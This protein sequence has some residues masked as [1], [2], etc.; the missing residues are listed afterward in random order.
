VLEHSGSEAGAIVAAQYYAER[1]MI[2]LGICDTGFGI[3]R[4]IAPA[5]PG[6][7]RTDLEAIKWALVPGVSGTTTHESGTE[8][9]AGAGLFIVKCM[10]FLAR[11]YF[12]IYSGSGVYKLLKRRPDVKTALLDRKSAG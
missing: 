8:T 12:L 5:W 7:A 3:R 10:S 2:R 11:N 9:N 1:H 4:T 6:H